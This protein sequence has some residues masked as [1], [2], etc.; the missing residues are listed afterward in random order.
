MV[1]LF[2]HALLLLVGSSLAIAQRPEIPDDIPLDK[3]T[4]D[5][6]E[7]L[8]PDELAAV[9]E[10]Y[11]EA[12]AGQVPAPPELI[13]QQE[14]SLYGKSPAV[15]PSPLAKGTGTWADAYAHVKA[16][17][18]QMTNEEK[19]NTTSLSDSGV[20]AIPRL[21][22]PGLRLHDGPNGLNA[23]EEVTAYASGITVG[24]SWNKDL[25]H[26]RGQISNLL[27]P[28]I[29]PLGRTVAGGRNWESFSVDPYLCG[30]MGAKTVLGIQ[31]NVIATAKH[32]VLNEQET[33]RNPSMFGFSNASVSSN[34]D[35]KTMH[36]YYLWP[37]Q[38]AVKAGVGSVMCSYQRVNGSHSCQNSWT[39]N[40]LLKTELGFQGILTSWFKFAQFDPANPLGLPKNISKAHE[41]SSSIDPSPEAKYIIRQGA[42]EGAVLVKNV[43]NTLPLKKPKIL[44]LF[45][46]DAHTPLV[47]SPTGANSKY[48]IG[49]QSVNRTK[50][51]VQGL[52][53]GVGEYPSAATLGTLVGGGGSSSVTPQYINS[54]F[55]AFQQRA[56]EDGTFLYWDFNS[57]DPSYSESDA[58]LVF[59]NEFA[60]EIVDRVSLADQYSD[61]LVMNTIVSIH[62]AGVRLVDRWID[63]PNVTAVIFAHLPGQD[64]GPAL[65]DIMYGEQAP[66][67]KLPYT[68]AKNESDYSEELLWPVRPD[69]SL[70]Y[71]TH[72]DFTEGSYIDYCRF[73]ALNIE[74]RF[75]F[76]FGLTYT[77]FNYSDL[78]VCHTEAN[79]SFYSPPGEVMED[80]LKSLWDVVAIVTVR[81]LNTGEVTASEIPQLYVGIPGAP[82]KQLRGFE[83][84][85]LHPKEGKSVSFPLTRRDLSLWDTKSQSWYLERGEYKLYVGSSSRDI[86]LT[87]SLTF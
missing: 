69:N 59:I 23:L 82:I 30:Q 54:P 58:C 79:S 72:A 8:P 57:E 29:G 61:N 68:V 14:L 85:P 78:E 5:Y 6:L 49:Y 33:D 25:A 18:N 75:E 37:F 45:G 46:Y 66:S 17:V 44:S 41:G 48:S 67:G 2:V 64:A 42:V 84:I 21:G 24:A 28:T 31:E 43:N 34:I 39:Q 38:D 71:Y 3:G 51:Q 86:R 53:V 76:G 80:G 87:G 62:N 11:Q 81:V 55:D 19:A 63:H 50:V 36:E 73:D 56:Y 32:F 7:S 15:Y 74:P 77:T 22:F 13:T 9:L 12:F 47:N 83:K 52:F 40:G 4:R 20:P 60:S 1:H 27:G 35:D 16:L 70:N 26:A 65:V 10:V